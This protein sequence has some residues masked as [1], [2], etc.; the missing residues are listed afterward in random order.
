MDKNIEKLI[1]KDKY[2]QPWRKNTATILFSLGMSNENIERAL[3]GR[4]DKKHI[5]QDACLKD[6]VPFSKVWELIK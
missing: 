2:L 3:T 1:N 4:L 5:C 6:H